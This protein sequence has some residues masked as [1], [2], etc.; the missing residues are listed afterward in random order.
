MY[1]GYTLDNPP[2]LKQADMHNCLDYFRS[3]IDQICEKIIFDN[4]DDSSTSF[5]CMMCS[6]SSTFYSLSKLNEHMHNHSEKTI[7]FYLNNYFWK[8]EY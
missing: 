5:T 8:M 3:R 4:Y 6:F 7:R 1:E 2:K